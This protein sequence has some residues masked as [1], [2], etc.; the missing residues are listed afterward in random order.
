[1]TLNKN[2]D[3]FSTLLTS[4]GASSKAVRRPT[5]NAPVHDITSPGASCNVGLISATE[6]VTVSAGSMIGFKLEPGKT[7]YH[8]GPA[9]MYLGRAPRKA[10]DWD[11][12]GSHWFKVR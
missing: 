9:A 10:A 1:M 7:V 8:K 3:V 12:S 2:T 6:T 5:E 11:G 4:S